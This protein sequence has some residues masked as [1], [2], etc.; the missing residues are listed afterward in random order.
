MSEALLRVENLTKRFGGLYALQDVSFA[1]KSGSITA[2]I[3]PNGAG[4]TTLFSIIAGFLKPDRGRA[5]LEGKDLIGLRPDQIARLGLVRTF[6]LVRLFGRMSVLENVLV[7]FHTRTRG[8]LLASIVRPPWVR[9]Q[10][11]RVAEEARGLLDLVG[12]GEQADALAGSLTYGQQRLLEIARALAAKPTLVMLD[13]PAAGL[14]PVETE[15]LSALIR[16]IRERGSTV[17]FIEHDMELVMGI[18]EEIHVLDFGKK[19]ASGDAEAIKEHP[20]VLEAYLGD[21]SARATAG[22]G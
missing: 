4:K 16:T 14:N 2:V 10:E 18:A 17:L 12:L 8:E 15:N 11:R 13:E 21:V 9:A 7:G 3:G 22:E 5:E 19:I 6:Q 1:V 20:A